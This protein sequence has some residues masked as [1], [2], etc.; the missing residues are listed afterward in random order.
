MI[1]AP[2]LLLVL[3]VALVAPA[4]DALL[5]EPVPDLPGNQ[6]AEDLAACP[7]L[8]PGVAPI[9]GLAVARA[10]R[11]FDGL[12]LTMSTRPLACGEPASQHGYC[13]SDDDL[14]LTLG[15][16]A[17]QAVPGVYSFQSPIYVEYETPG[18]SVAGGG[19]E[20]SLASV[21]LFAIT[22]TCVTGRIVGL[23]D[24]HGPFDGGFRA[25]RCTP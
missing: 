3:A 25:P 19:G 18:A 4:C 11:R 20:L 15:I 7:E 2:P 21:E 6:S 1:H 16:P 24:Q 14:G 9:E 8:P 12:V 22:D 13:T 10:V 5:C 17:E 23:V